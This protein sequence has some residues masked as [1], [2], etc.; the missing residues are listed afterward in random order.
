MN[1][2]EIL[3][4]CR[5][6]TENPDLRG[7]AEWKAENPGAK[8]CGA[9]PVYVPFEVIAAAGM[10]PVA[11]FGGSTAIEVERADARLQSFVCAISRSTLEL[12][13][14]GRFDAL[15]AFV[16]PTTCD[17]ARNLS[18][19]WTHN[20]PS[21]RT[22]YLHLPQNVESPSALAYGAQEF[23]RLGKALGE[24]SGHLPSDRDLERSIQD[25]NVLRRLL[26]RLYQL[27]QEP[28]RL[29]LTECALL[30]RGGAGLSAAGHGHPLGTAPGHPAG[31]AGRAPAEASRYGAG[32]AGGGLLRTAPPGAPPGHGGG[33]LRGRG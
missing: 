32:G 23:R 21:M 3:A 11:T 20:F 24:V 33:R 6:R 4:Q 25:Y 16:F 8:A 5:E 12:G 1:L 17:V 26:R 27:R 2:A 31:P 19:I 22:V 29:G 30:V 28:G 9:F 7:V 14:T 13:M 15:D 10:L 18:G